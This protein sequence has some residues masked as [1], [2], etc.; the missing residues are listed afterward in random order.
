MECKVGSSR[1]E[2]GRVQSSS[3]LPSLQNRGS[4]VFGKGRRCG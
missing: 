3:E 2:L 1:R 4:V